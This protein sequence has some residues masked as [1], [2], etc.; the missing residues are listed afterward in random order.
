M[1]GRRKNTSAIFEQVTKPERLWSRSEVL[2][3]PS[4]VPRE[5]GLYAWYF[6][7]IPPQVPTD[8]CI[9]SRGLTLLYSGISPK[10]PPKGGKK[11]SAQTLWN[12]VRYHFNWNAEGS[13][14]RLTL[15]TLLART[16]GIELRRV[17]SGKRMTFENG[18]GTLS[19]WMDD[20]AFVTWVVHS[21]PWELETEVIQNL[22]LPLNLDQNRS[23][24]FH[25]VLSEARRQAKQNAREKAVVNQAETR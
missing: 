11:P 5:P 2:A 1:L 16:L 13:T 3:K 7:D 19:R 14:L 22:S 9:T 21:R 25:P 10:A 6:R 8:D 20:S 24:A 12:R 23:H 18:E 4:P 15:G 17:G